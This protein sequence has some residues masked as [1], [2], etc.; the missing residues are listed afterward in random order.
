MKVFYRG[1]LIGIYFLFLFLLVIAWNNFSY[2]QLMLSLAFIILT[3][4]LNANLLK[5]LQTNIS[6]S[7]IYPFIVPSLIFLEPFYGIIYVSIFHLLNYLNTA[8]Y[9][10]LFNAS[11]Q[12]IGF[13]VGSYIVHLYIDEKA[14]FNPQFFLIIVLATFLFSTIN[15]ISVTLVI[16]LEKENFDINSLIG[17]ISA[18]KTSFFTN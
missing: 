10:R 17:Q 7:I 6:Y 11:I 3:K 15:K 8:F 12:G 5:D 18:F 4:M 16:S 14:I 2:E 1:Y 9:K 13:Y